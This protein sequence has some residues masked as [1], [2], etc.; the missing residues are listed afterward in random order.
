MKKPKM[1]QIGFFTQKDIERGIYQFVI[2]H[3]R[4]MED[5]FY[6]AS[7][8]FTT[9]EELLRRIYARATSIY[10]I[11]DEEKIQ[12]ELSKKSRQYTQYKNTANRIILNNKKLNKLQHKNIIKYKILILLDKIRKNLFNKWVSDINIDNQFAI[13]IGMI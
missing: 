11:K 2:D 12:N 13:N 1:K 3:A 8:E 4:P 9:K 6:K 10:R 5:N 7:F